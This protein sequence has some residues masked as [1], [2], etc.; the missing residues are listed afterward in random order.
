MDLHAPLIAL[1]S[2][3]LDPSARD[4]AFQYVAHSGA[5]HSEAGGEARGGSSRFFP[6]ARERA[7]HGNRC[8]SH[9][10]ELAIER[11]HAVDQ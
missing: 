2:A 8:I 4:E 9:A 5:L 6:N 3:P 11:A 1:M 7:V 10:L